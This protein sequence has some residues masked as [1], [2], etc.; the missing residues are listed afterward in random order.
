[1]VHPDFEYFQLKKSG[2]R[3][4]LL[5]Y[6]PINKEAHYVHKLIISCIWYKKLQTY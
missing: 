1:M 2:H 6:K 5:I 4:N 3:C